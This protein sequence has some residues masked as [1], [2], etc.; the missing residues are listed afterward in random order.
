MKNVKIILNEFKYYIL[1]ILILIFGLSFIPYFIFNKEHNY[2]IYVLFY[3]LSLIGV[4]LIDGLVALIVHKLPKK[5]FDY[6]KKIYKQRKREKAYFR[7]IKIHKWKDSIPEIGKIACGFA[8]DK[9]EE[10]TNLVYL[11]SFITE[12]CY[13]EIIHFISMIIGFVVVFILPLRYILFIGLEVGFVNAV[14][15]YP[16]FLI[17]RYNRPRLLIVLSRQRKKKEVNVN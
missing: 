17:Q 13:A 10:P 7:L 3:F 12:T 9:I 16:S 8:K 1:I 11:E 5:C 4:L 15:N 6:N 2:F 14:M